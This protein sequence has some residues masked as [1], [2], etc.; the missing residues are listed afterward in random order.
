M[1]LRR[2]AVDEKEENNP[3]ANVKE[4]FHLLFDTPAALSVNCMN[5]HTLLRL[6]LLYIVLD[7]PEW[8]L[9]SSNNEVASVQ[10]PHHDRV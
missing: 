2:Y 4:S 7:V 9:S 8:H 10:K 5:A 6:L 1:E 3:E